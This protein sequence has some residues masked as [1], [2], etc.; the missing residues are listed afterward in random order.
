[1]LGLEC[2][3]FVCFILFLFCACLCFRFFFFQHNLPWFFWQDVS[4][5]T[6]LLED[7]SRQAE[8]A[9]GNPFR[10]NTKVNKLKTKNMFGMIS[11]TLLYTNDVLK[12]IWEKYVSPKVHKRKIYLLL[13]WFFCI[14]IKK[15]LA[16]VSDIY[17]GFTWPELELQLHKP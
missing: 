10:G 7:G 16:K 6:K 1:M 3:R 13:Y 8:C 5:S 9:I 4:C 11:L 2:K 14:T 15:I 12:V 17:C